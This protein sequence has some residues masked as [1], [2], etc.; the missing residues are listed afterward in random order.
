MNL[1]L[2]IS[3]KPPSSVPV[4]TPQ[5]GIRFFTSSFPKV[6]FYEKNQFVL[7]ILSDYGNIHHRTTKSEHDE[8]PSVT[9]RGK[10]GHHRKISSKH[11]SKGKSLLSR[12]AELGAPGWLC[13]PFGQ[14]SLNNSFFTKVYL[15][16]CHERLKTHDVCQRFQT[17]H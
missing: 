13:S 2:T 9:R 15:G 16:L 5:T 7:S 1:L 8:A 14:I 3:C 11:F 4:M 6:H 17:Q 10:A 12:G